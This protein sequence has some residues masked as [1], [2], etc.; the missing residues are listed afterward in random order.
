MGGFL[1][2]D[3]DLQG[4]PAWLPVSLAPHEV[5]TNSGKSMGE[6]LACSPLSRRNIPEIPQFFLE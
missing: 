6:R 3:L 4:L 5:K 2:H 1:L